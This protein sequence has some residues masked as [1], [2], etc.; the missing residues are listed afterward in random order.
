VVD[1]GVVDGE[2]APQFLSSQ[3]RGVA[4]QGG[5]GAAQGGFQ[6]VVGDFD[7]PAFGVGLGDLF[8]RVAVVI[9]RVWP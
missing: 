4:A 3:L 9:E 1:Q 7:L 5:V 2:Q 8:G 6:V